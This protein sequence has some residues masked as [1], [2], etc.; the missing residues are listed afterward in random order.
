MREV[1]IDSAQQ[2]ANAPVRR[3]PRRRVVRLETAFLR[4]AGVPA[5]RVPVV[6]L[7]KGGGLPAARVLGVEVAVTVASPEKAALGARAVQ[8]CRLAPAKLRQSLRV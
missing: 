1:A 6:S 4:A 8:A 5:K 7:L 3:D 2:Q